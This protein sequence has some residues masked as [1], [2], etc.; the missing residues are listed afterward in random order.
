MEYRTLIAKPIRRGVARPIFCV[1]SFGIAICSAG[2]RMCETD[3][4]S[5]YSAYSLGDLFAMHI[6]LKPHL[7]RG[8][9]NRIDGNGG[10]ADTV[11]SQFKQYFARE[12]VPGLNRHETE[13]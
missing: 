13:S 8:R 1:V 3:N 6:Q 7:D 12:P 2:N 9:L 10:N 5:A 11:R 4:G